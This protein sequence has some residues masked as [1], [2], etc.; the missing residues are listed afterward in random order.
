MAPPVIEFKYYSVIDYL[1]TVHIFSDGRV[2]GGSIDYYVEGITDER[3][4]YSTGQHHIAPEK[5]DALAMRIL[6]AIDEAQHYTG[7]RYCFMGIGR[8][9]EDT[10][11]IT[12]NFR[13]RRESVEWVIDPPEKNTP[14]LLDE[15]VTELEDIWRA[16]PQKAA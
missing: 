8:W 13:G 4:G 7:P 2:E 1:K 3:R 10:C 9:Y 11:H 5:V 12:V 6:G 15:I 14:P 16:T